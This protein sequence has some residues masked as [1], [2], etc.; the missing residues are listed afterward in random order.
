MTLGEMRAEIE[1]LRK[2]AGAEKALR[3]AVAES[4]GPAPEYRERQ[5]AED[6]DLAA[7][8]EVLKLAGGSW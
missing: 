1:R 8:L 2:L 5:I 3:L 7:A 4:W 6:P